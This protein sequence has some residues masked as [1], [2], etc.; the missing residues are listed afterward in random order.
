MT[1]EYTSLRCTKAVR[2]C[3][4]IKQVLRLQR[5]F[6]KLFISGEIGHIDFAIADNFAS[7]YTAAM[8]KWGSK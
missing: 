1:E 5:L 8:I 3:R 6:T 7:G 4:D 2:K